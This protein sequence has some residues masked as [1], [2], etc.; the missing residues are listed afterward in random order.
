MANALS[1]LLGLGDIWIVPETLPCP[2]CGDTMRRGLVS[3]KPTFWAS[4]FGMRLVRVIDW[5][6]SELAYRCG[7]CAAV[8][9]AKPSTIGRK[10]P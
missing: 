6:G 3:V 4:F 5:S 8:L 1:R 7:K 2:Q 9:I 10:A